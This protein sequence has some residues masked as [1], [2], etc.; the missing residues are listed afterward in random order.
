MPKPV[1]HPHNSPDIKSDREYKNLI[2]ECPNVK[3]FARELILQIILLRRK[4]DIEINFQSLHQTTVD[5]ID[6]I[7]SEF[8]YR[9]INS[10]IDTYI[11]YGDEK[12]RYQ[13]LILSQYLCALMALEMEQNSAVEH[14]LYDAN[15][16]DM[17]SSFNV[18]SCTKFSNLFNRIDKN[19]IDEPFHSFW[20]KKFRDRKSVV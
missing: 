9:W 11:D 12:Q 16:G 10:I 3:P 18:G 17:T 4:K 15:F 6:H 8:N 5:E 2:S 14:Y 7:C 13:S 19:I 1:T 20:F